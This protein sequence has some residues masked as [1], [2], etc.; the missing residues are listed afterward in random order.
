MQIT[1]PLLVFTKP[2]RQKMEFTNVEIHTLSNVGL[3]K[4][5]S[6]VALKCE[7]M[8]QES[9]LDALIKSLITALTEFLDTHTYTQV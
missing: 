9:D 3:A 2:I 8:L 7:S 5:G 6:D 1:I 4:F